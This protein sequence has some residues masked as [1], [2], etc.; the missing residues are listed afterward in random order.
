MK[1]QNFLFTNG[2]AYV[3]VKA[4]DGY[5]AWEILSAEVGVQQWHGGFEIPLP[6]SWNIQ[7]ICPCG[8]ASGYSFCSRACFNEF[9]K[10]A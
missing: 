3:T 4:I 6:H 2:S 7:V 10:I 8:E 9:S 1:L 5:H